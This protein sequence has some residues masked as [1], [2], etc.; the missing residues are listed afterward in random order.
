MLSKSIS[1]WSEMSDI[2]NW[3]TGR[4]ILCLC[5]RVLNVMAVHNGKKTRKMNYN[6]NKRVH[7]AHWKGVR[8]QLNGIC[9]SYCIYCSW[10]DKSLT[11][12][13]HLLHYRLRTN[14]PKIP[15]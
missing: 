6:I 3:K 5:V 7:L 9:P 13:A 15:K 12:T 4:F 10:V 11:T 14:V 8:Y 2:D 1:L